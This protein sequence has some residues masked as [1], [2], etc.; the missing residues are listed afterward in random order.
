MISNRLPRM[1]SQHLLKTKRSFFKT[2]HRPPPPPRSPHYTYQQITSNI[3]NLE[4]EDFGDFMDETL[5]ERRKPIE[6]QKLDTEINSKILKRE[7]V[8]DFIGISLK[9]TSL[10]AATTGLVN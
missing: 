2:P 1:L 8:N 7:I 3:K 5:I 10:R 6:A 9:Y 4:I